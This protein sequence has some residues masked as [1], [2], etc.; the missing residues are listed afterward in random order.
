MR[1]L[2]SKSLKMKERLRK[3]QM[4]KKVYQHNRM[5]Q[6]MKLRPV[7]VTEMSLSSPLPNGCPANGAPAMG[8]GLVVLGTT[9]WIYN[10]GPSST[11]T[12]LHGSHLD[13]W[14]MA[15]FLLQGPAQRSGFRLGLHIWGC[16]ARGHR[17]L[18][19]E[20]LTDDVVKALNQIYDNDNS[21]ITRQDDPVWI[22]LL[23]MG[24]TAEAGHLWC[25]NCEFVSSFLTHLF[26]CSFNFLYPYWSHGC[27]R[28]AISSECNANHFVMVICQKGFR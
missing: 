25:P 7:V 16:L 11:S 15:Q 5:A 12:C 10:L 4:M 21:N 27:V 3:L 8:Q 13:P 23:A 17:F 28:H 18:Q 14:F 20:R 6:L 19:L 24:Y 22:P 2:H 9:H 26:V 1:K